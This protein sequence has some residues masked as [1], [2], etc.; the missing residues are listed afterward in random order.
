MCM[1]KL[2]YKETKKD[3]KY[4]KSERGVGDTMLRSSFFFLS[5]FSKM[6]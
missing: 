6:R 3:G 5:E 4:E 1:P 2:N